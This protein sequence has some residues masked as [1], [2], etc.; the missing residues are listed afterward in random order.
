MKSSTKSIPVQLT[1]GI[2]VYIQATADDADEESM[3]VG[4]EVE[5]DVALK[6]P[7]VEGIA[8]AIEGVAQTVKVGLDKVSPTKA[9]VEFS[10]EFGFESGQLTALIVQGSQKANL[11]IALEWEKGK[12]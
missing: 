5:S 4:D 6:F 12:K 8:E 2:K 7:T 1:N 3:Q 11:K 10:L 9:R